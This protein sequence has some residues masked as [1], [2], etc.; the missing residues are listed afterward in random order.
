VSFLYAQLCTRLHGW[1]RSYSWLGDKYRIA[2]YAGR[3]LLCAA[4][5]HRKDKL[6]D[7]R[8]VI[9][10]FLKINTLHRA[11]ANLFEGT[12]FPMHAA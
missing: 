1:E 9:K 10:M 2:A 5:L 11:I 8:L 3:F 12:C 4:V 6:N 7:E